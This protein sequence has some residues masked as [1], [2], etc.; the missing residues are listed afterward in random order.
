MVRYYVRTGTTGGGD[1]DSPATDVS[2]SGYSGRKLESVK[3]PQRVSAPKK[4]EMEYLVKSGDCLS[5]IAQSELGSVK[6]LQRL[7]EVN[8][9]S[10]SSTLRVGQRLILPLI[11]E[12]APVRG[13]DLKRTPAP[14]SDNKDWAMVTVLEG[15]SLWKIAAR[16]FGDGN[17]YGEI[18]A[19]N[20]LKSETL[21]PG[22]KLRVQLSAGAALAM[23]GAKQ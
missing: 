3:E 9:L 16:V 8:G 12:T 13:E 6:H 14:V 4:K 11:G 18:M 15:D 5:K 23:G 22:T 7:L 19:W 10:S 20:Q 17:R 2:V 21:Q 1:F